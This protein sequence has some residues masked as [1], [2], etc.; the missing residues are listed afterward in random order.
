MPTGVDA[1]FDLANIPRD[2]LEAYPFPAFVLILRR[3]ANPALPAHPFDQPW[4][5]LGPASFTEPLA[6]VW[7]NRRW[8]RVAGTRHLLDCITVDG[9]R[10]LGD[11]LSGVR[12]LRERE[13]LAVSWAAHGGVAASTTSDDHL[14]SAARQFV[15]KRG[16]P[17][18]AEGEYAPLAPAALEEDL[19]EETETITLDF[20]FPRG[21]ALLELVMAPLPLYVRGGAA[22]VTNSLGVITMR[23]RSNLALFRAG[24]SASS[25]PLSALQRAPSCKDPTLFSKPRGGAQDTLFNGQSVIHN[26]VTGNAI[27]IK[28]D[29]TSVPQPGP[30][31]ETHPCGLPMDVRTLLWTKDWSA[32]PLGPLSQWP[33][34]LRMVMGLCMGFPIRVCIWWGRDLTMLYNEAFAQNFSKHPH[35]YGASGAEAWAELWSGAGSYT[36]LVLS[37]TSI[38]KDDDLY[39]YRDSHGK[40]YETYRS[41]V[42]SVVMNDEGEFGGVW[43]AHR[44]STAKVVSD[45][46]VA[47]LRELAERTSAARTL[48]SFETGLL[49]T[50]HAHPKEAPFALLYLVD[51]RLHV[52]R[53]EDDQVRLRYAGGVGI[54]DTHP[55]APQVVTLERGAV[56]DKPASRPRT[57]STDWPWPFEE[58]MRTRAP[59]VVPNIRALIGGYPVRAWDELPNAAVVV[60]LNLN[61]EDGLPGAVLVLG[62]SCR[63]DYDSTYAEFVSELRFQ[64]A[65]YLAAVRLYHGDQHRIDNL[66]SLNSAKSS[67]FSHVSHELFTPITL[68]SGPLDDLLAEMR[69]G[70]HMGMVELAR[71]NVR[72]LKRLVQM[73]MYLSRLE[74]GR[75]K[76]SF[77]REN[78]GCITAG[79]AGMFLKAAHKCQIDY[80]IACDETQRET[81]VDRELWE[82]IL[83]VLIGNAIELSSHRSMEV[84]LEYEGSRAIITIGDTT[85]AGANGS[86]RRSEASDTTIAL[87]FA[88]KLVQLHGGVFTRM[89][90]ADEGFTYRVELPL[91]SSHLPEEALGDPSDQVVPRVAA[92][93]GHE[94]LDE[95]FIAQRE[96]EDAI[97]S[98]PN[99][100][101]LLSNG[102]S[103]EASGELS[104][105]S[106]N[107]DH[108][109]VYFTPHD[110]ILVVDD[111]PDSRRYIVSILRPFCKV[112]E[113]ANAEEALDRFDEFAP[114]LIISEA[115]LPDL[116]GPGLIAE[117][118]AGTRAQR[119]VPI[120][121]LTAAD[122]VRDGGTFRADDTLS[123]PFNARELITRADMQMQLGKKR[124][125]L[126]QLFEERTAELRLL[127]EGSPVGMF[128]VDAEAQV[129][130]ANPTWLAMTSFS[131]EQLPRCL[132][133][134]RHLLTKE[135]YA[136]AVP[137]WEAFSKGDAQ[138]MVIEV[139]W[140]NGRWAHLTVYRLPET[141][142]SDEKS[143]IACSMDITERKLNEEMQRQRVE[144]AEMRRAEAE[145]ARRQQELL[146]DITSHEMRNPVSS[147]MQCAA[148]VK[149][150][151][152]FLHDQFEL[153]LKEN[154][155][156]YPTQ[157]LVSTLV[158]DLEALDSIY[159]CGLAQE[160]ICNDVLSL[161][162]F[163]VSTN[164]RGNAHGIIAIF[165]NEARMNRI[166]LQLDMSPSFQDLGVET[167]MTDPVRLGQVVSNLLSNA[168]RF[169]ANSTERRVRL[170]MDIGVEPP[171]DDGCSKPVPSTRPPP[172]KEGMPIYLYVSVADTGPGLTETEL[173]NLFQRFSQASPMTHT[174]FGGSGLGLFVCRMIVE[175]MG[176][177]IEVTSEY[178]KGSEFRFFI[179]CRVG[180][181]KKHAPAPGVERIPTITRRDGQRRVL[182][183]EDNVIN[184]TVLLRQ[185]K[186]VGIIAEA[187]TNGLEGL[188][189]VKAATREVGT[190][191]DCVLMDLEMPVMDG[192]TATRQ[193]RI[194]EAAGELD[195]TPIVALT[196]NAR[197]AQLESA[198]ADFD[199]V[200]VKPYRLDDLLQT[201]ERV[202]ARE[203]EAR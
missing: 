33:A 7:V 188:E 70:P 28:Q 89:M 71:R 168:T 124:R 42:W 142:L 82:K 52:H 94:V 72:R 182:V 91:G 202:M 76:G 39:L 164:I 1:A 106:S 90:E 192:Y 64:A 21:K 128:R 197:H 79:V 103:S 149:T 152:V 56:M 150:N 98:M 134:W 110:V 31:D 99:G 159:Q 93:F 194:A 191:Y 123:K 66:A 24:S 60:P 167:I 23:P 32:T 144:D 105:G 11:W 73:I 55:S 200:V 27:H 151:L 59:I 199:A 122:V 196:G 187:A 45:R 130:Y 136:E 50:L 160:R 35:G 13:R 96:R 179:Q 101:S 155:A 193:V 78:L 170:S 46:R 77:H 177:R 67:L 40:T 54:P 201:M 129:L 62:L 47:M 174:V 48:H 18:A 4:N 15:S 9:A 173:G 165:Q 57:P 120:L 189:K 95:L 141:R 8:S 83:F 137:V 154:R 84:R 69:E 5:A 19:S 186:H 58:A 118:R 112:V 63:L 51:Q 65:S 171:L 30:R 85:S 162:M 125:A 157:Q 100:F 49:E 138:R 195:V 131:K 132:D 14:E 92:Q 190:G 2:Y 36:E 181:I 133:D 139:Q 166:A 145:E 113:A 41:G 16:P 10:R 140:K 88:K 87:E 81:F 172:L 44:D 135:S 25:P 163:D 68:I 169:T 3:P 109:T 29:G 147:L 12:S 161:E 115:V 74:N 107:H 111:V 180:E 43:Y 38:Y 37:G 156:F 97:A 126:E 185:L 86:G 22:S 178:G 184:R 6:P 143:F 114:D 127:T 108:G 153:V 17:Y 104:R 183:V 203:R 75:F 148:L 146:I 175:R 26:W 80:T 198:M 34:T 61:S 176:G 117:L 158:E 102:H 121:L 116:D 119:I 20:A 53:E